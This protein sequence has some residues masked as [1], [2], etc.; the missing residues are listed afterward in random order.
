MSELFNELMTYNQSNKPIYLKIAPDM[1]DD[2]VG[3]I[4]EFALESKASGI[5]ATNTTTMENLGKGGV[6]GELL[7]ERAKRKYQTQGF[8]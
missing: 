1:S 3:E 6:S 7:Y 4:S 5:I 8:E 2:Q